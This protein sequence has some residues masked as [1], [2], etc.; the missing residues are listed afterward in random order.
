[1][2]LT[3]S[4]VVAS[5]G[6]L[7][8][9]IL[10]YAKAKRNLANTS[11]VMM[12]ATLALVVAANYFSLSSKYSPALTL[13]W[14]RVVMFLV[15]FLMLFLYYFAHSYLSRY[16]FKL[17]VFLWLLA[18][19]LVVAIVNITPISY[20]SVTI[21][22]L[23]RIIP[24]TGPG[25]ALN[26]FQILPL[27]TLAI[28][29]MIRNARKAENESDARKIRY[30]LWLLIFCFGLQ[31][32][33]SFV[34]V[35][36][37]NYT[38]L[39]PVGSFLILIFT[40]WTTIS[41][42]RFKYF[43][44]KILGTIVFAAILAILMFAEIFTAD[45]W[46]MILFRVVVFLSVGIIGWQFIKSVQHEIKQKEELALLAGKLREANEHLKDLDKMKDDFLSMAS[47]EL[48][49]PLAAIE[50]YLSMILDEGMGGAEDLKPQTRDYLNRIYSASERLA[51][52]VKDLLNVSRIESGRIHL[53]YA[54]ASIEDIIKQTVAEIDPKLKEKKHTIC[55]ELPKE[56][57]PK[58]WMDVTRITEVSLNLLANAVKYTDD[59]GHLEIGAREKDKHLLVWVKD[60]G[61]GI[62]ADKADRV[63][64]KFTQ[65]DVLKDEVKGTGLGMY[66][67][68]KFV[69]LHNGKI[70]FESDGDGKGTTFYF[71]LP[72]IKDRPFDPYEGEGAVLR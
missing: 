31:I 1:M 58:S 50:G 64:Q 69:E 2:L 48:N 26:S 70:W 49:T 47:H 18:G 27:F 16:K 33:T 72:V 59:G 45:G 25:L 10:V 52:I 17:N 42:F 57:L 34:I 66:I 67:S 19:S 32:I 5:I 14:I 68:R 35:L 15:P 41:I 44:I 65:V 40:I 63:F 21:D 22:N 61:R 38:D 53:V 6:C 9:A 28:V 51:E 71:S 20:I 56:P 37:F 55:V 39:V 24:K 62:P 4:T 12:I 60:N 7:S 43:N 36:I 11:F 54:E 23:G 8:L 46:Q 3:W 29:T 13:F 30:E